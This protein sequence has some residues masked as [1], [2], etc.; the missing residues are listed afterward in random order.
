MPINCKYFC[1]LKKL[2]SEKIM[3]ST[4]IFTRILFSL[5]LIEYLLIL[6]RGN[7]H[8]KTSLFRVVN[9]KENSLLIYCASS[10]KKI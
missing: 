7:P 1:S 4:I 8:F 2:D 3:L 10:A 9:F 6:D 5:N